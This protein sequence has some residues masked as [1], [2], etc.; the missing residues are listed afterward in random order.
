MAYSSTNPPALRSQAIA[1]PREWVYAST[2]ASTAVATL[3]YFT[4][5]VERGMRA[6]DRVEVRN[7][8]AGTVTSHLVISSS[9]PSTAGLVIGDPT[10]IGSTSNT[11]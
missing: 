9:L 6:G 7:T 11:A 3:G 1:G 5:G 4:D 2:D 10:T 8:S